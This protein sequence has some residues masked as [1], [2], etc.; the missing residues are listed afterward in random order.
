MRTLTVGDI[1]EI[2]DGLVMGG[3]TPRELHGWCE[4]GAIVPVAGGEG[5][6]N[7]RQFTPLQVVAIAYAAQ[8]WRY[9]ARISAVKGIINAVISLD[10]TELR[11]KFASSCVVILPSSGV[12][13]VPKDI[14]VPEEFDLC[15]LYEAV[16]QEIERLSSHRPVKTAGRK[17]GLMKDEME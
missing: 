9:G 4:H 11:D 14:D 16:M 12:L 2:T 3:L 6:G 7:H 8:W 15:Y 17:R 10:E 5:Y 1:Q 13:E